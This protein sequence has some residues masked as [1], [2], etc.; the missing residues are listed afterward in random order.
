[1][2]DI[3]VVVADDQALVRMGLCTLIG[4]TPGLVVVAE[5]ADGADAVRCAEEQR[6]D[7]I[8]MDV[9]MPKMDGIE[10]TRRICSNPELAGV[11]IVILT[12]F[13]VDDYVFQALRAGASGFLL[14][15]SEPDEI[16][17]AVRVAAEGDALLA[18]SVT[19]RLIGDYAR[20]PPGRQHEPEMLDGLT[21]REREIVSL[22]AR[23]L[24]NQEIAE[25]LIVSPLT[26]KT[27]VSNILSKTGVRDRVQLVVLA[28]ESG[29]V[30]PGETTPAD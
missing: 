24:N 23:G 29:L 25:Q 2:S 5:A 3:R 26:V 30:Q 6:P 11:R 16:V 22:V 27:H 14:K 8:L 10:A 21:D 1:V 4:A 9:R 20:K 18:P 13:D 12:T 28:Y 7:V 17:R 15:D 19:R